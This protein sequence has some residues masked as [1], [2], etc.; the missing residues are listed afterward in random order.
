MRNKTGIKKNQGH[1]DIKAVLSSILDSIPH[2]VI[3]LKERHIIFANPAV[4]A[5]FGWKPEELIG[6]TTRVL[7]RSDTEY[8]E[9]ARYAY[10]AL[11]IQRTFIREYPCR[12]KDGR[13]ITCLVSSSRI[14]E[15]LKDKMIVVT[16]S[17][18]TEMRRAEE[19]LRRANI[20]N[21][22]LLETCV[23]PLVAIDITGKISD[24]NAATER[25]TGHLREE[26]IGTDFSDYFTDPGK[27]RTGYWKVFKEGI[28]YNYP[29]EIRHRDGQVTPV[30]YNASVYRDELDNI[31]GVFA[32]VRDITERKKMI[33]ALRESERRYRSI[34]EDQTELI[35]RFLPDFTVTFVNEAYCRFFNIKKEDIQGR[36]FMTLIPEDDRQEVA[37]QISSLSVEN[38]LL[39]H[40]YSVLMPDGTIG[41]QQW[42]NRAIFDEH[43]TLVSY[44]AVGHNITDRKRTEEAL[45]EYDAHLEKLVEEHTAEL[46]KT[47]KLMQKETTERMQTEV[48]L[49]EA[50]SRLLNVL[51]GL[52]AAVY[53]IDMNSY[54]LL[55]INKY[56]RDWFGDVTGKICWQSVQNQPGPCSFCDQGKLSA[57]MGEPP[58]ILTNEHYNAARGIWFS[59]QHRSI[60]WIDG[61]PVHLE[62]ATNI[63]KRKKA[64]QTVYEFQLQQKAILDNIPDIA[65]LKD[66]ESKYIA[67]NEAFGTACGLKPEDIVEM[68][69]F[70]VWPAN[71][72]E[73]YREDDKRVVECGT[74]KRVEEPLVDKNGREIWL[75]TIKTPIFNDTGDIIGT[76]GIS[77]DITRRKH[78]E[79]ELRKREKELETKSRNLEEVNIALKILLKRREDDKTELEE[80][81]LANVKELVEPYIEKL[82]K[83]GLNADQAAYATV[84]ETHLNDI[85]SPFLHN[86]T[87]KYLNLT[88]REIQIANLIKEGKTTKEIADILNSSQ[89]AIDFHRNNIRNK[90]GLKKKSANLRSYLLSLS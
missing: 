30:M 52:N 46:T 80:K 48:L 62:I 65:W 43:G 74:R 1:E 13:D 60:H 44:Q 20:Y 2:A 86:L 4:E 25:I 28:M 41:W 69:D 63:T 50:H 87:S 37:D 27:A 75:E 83:T 8:E 68:T 3:G 84:I 40:E 22:N 77:R 16:Y 11:E 82:K 71:L 78:A 24:V 89:G 58:S 49:K 29:L 61:R 70:D 42:T 35:C 66:R 31:I 45:K 32:V 10:P 90:L 14:G 36:S 55:Y 15:I 21:R 38:P 72:A 9:I 85:I 67:V 26:L 34:V 57:P 73:K 17:D 12:H 19:S 76:A 51:D 79:E 56:M 7:Y 39:T 23:D 53:V 64:E 59:I 47:A 5:V 81:V 33:E 88:P 54:K 18:I 6:K